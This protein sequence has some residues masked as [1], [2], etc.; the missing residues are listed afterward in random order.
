MKFACLFAAAAALASHACS[1]GS[2]EVVVYASVDEIYARGIFE[3][4]TR[5]TGIAVR[6][7]YDTEEAKTLGLVHRLLAERG[8]P[9]ADVF[10]NGECS[11]TA[12]LDR[13]GILSPYRP[14]TAEGIGASWRDPDGAWTGFGARARVIV[15]NT[16][17]V[18]E[19]PATLEEL[20]RPPWKGRVAMANPLFGTTA[21][22]VAALF[23]VR[24]EAATLRLLEAL[25][26]NGVRLV[27]GNSHVRDLVAR[28]DCDVG[29]TDSDDVWIGKERGDPVAMVFPDQ[30]VT[31]TLIIPNSVALIRGA[32]H[33]TCGRAF[34][35]YLLRS[36]TEGRLASGRARQIPVRPEVPGPEGMPLLERLKIMNVDWSRLEPPE[37]F[38]EKVRSLFAS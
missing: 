22:H 29:L 7:V 21:T 5:E 17:R 18:Q 36:E 3:A 25:R 34:I 28:G 9:R 33:S 14:P 10:W 12:L 15:Y 8:S 11:R 24:G 31:G 32:P 6:A 37:V 23:H 16:N 4:F 1:R 35:D 38:L 2:R 26:S 19:P 13:E 27:G 20:T 30:D